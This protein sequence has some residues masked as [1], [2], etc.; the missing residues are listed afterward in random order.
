VSLEGGRA[1][2]VFG[3]YPTSGFGGARS[4]GAFY[5]LLGRGG[6]FEIDFRTNARYFNADAKKT[7][8]RA[9]SGFG[10]HGSAGV[11]QRWEQQRRK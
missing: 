6:V 10:S 11:E 9:F 4:A 3:S 7:L 2:L 8:L 5:L 1:Y